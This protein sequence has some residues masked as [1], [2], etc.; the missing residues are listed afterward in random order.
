MF[1]NGDEKVFAQKLANWIRRGYAELGDH[2][3]MGLGANVSQVNFMVEYYSSSIRHRNENRRINI[4]L[5][6]VR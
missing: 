1:H 3:G 4:R 2:A 5:F 6:Y